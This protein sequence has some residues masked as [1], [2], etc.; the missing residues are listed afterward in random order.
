MT[1]W[2]WRTSAV[3]LFGMVMAV[4]P[5]GAAA[6]QAPPPTPA[7]PMIV[8]SGS[9]IQDGT[10]YV[11]EISQDRADTLPRW[12]ARPG[13]EPPLSLGRARQAG[14][15]WLTAQTPEV[16][17][18]ELTSAN[19]LRA[20]SAGLWHYR[21]T[22]D[23]VLS[24]RRLPGGRDFTAEVLL[25]GS[26][27]EPRTESAP[28]APTGVGRGRGAPPAARPAEVGPA[29]VRV[30]GAITPPQRIRN[31]N[32]IYPPDAQADKVQGVVILEATIGVDGRVTDVRVL[33]S[34]PQLDA[35]ATS[36]VRQWEYTPTLVDGVAVPV[37]MT[38]TVNFTL[39]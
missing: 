6:P 29:P 28:V 35:A 4:Q 27:V 17:T 2:T 10:R 14:E 3:A 33:R 39:N 8:L 7:R 16:K 34:I 32:P 22:F 20:N 23:P 38:I 19:L 21:L 13:S 12:D 37:V 15:A 25:D 9:A 24:G 1:S 36:A 5:S 18:L 31:V 30:G 26:I 11:Y